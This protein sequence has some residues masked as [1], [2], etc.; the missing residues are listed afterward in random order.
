MRDL[1]DTAFW[2]AKIHIWYSH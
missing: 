1:Q 2:F